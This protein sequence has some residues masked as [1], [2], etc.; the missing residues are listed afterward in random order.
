MTTTEPKTQPLELDQIRLDGGTQVRVEINND[1]V[2]E[3]AEARKDGAVLPP[4]VVFFDGSDYWLAD[5]FH[6]FHSAKRNKAKSIR[7]EVRTGDRRE[8]ILCAVGSNTAHGLRRSNADKRNAI[9]TLLKDADWGKKSDR[10]I[11][12]TAH[13]SD[14]TVASVRDQLRKSAVGNATSA[15]ENGD[16][17]KRTGRD[18]KERAASSGGATANGDPSAGDAGKKS[19]MELFENLDKAIGKAIRDVDEVGMGAEHDE[20]L[21][22]LSQVL[23]KANRWRRKLA[24]TDDFAG[25]TAPVDGLKRPV[26]QEALWPAFR[27][28]QEISGKM[29]LV[30]SIRTFVGDLIGTDIGSRLEAEDLRHWDTSL[31]ALGKFLKFARPYAVC[32]YCNASDK[33]CPAC[34]GEGWINKISYDQ[35]PAEKKPK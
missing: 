8:A 16:S 15:T 12:E 1:A 22:D 24:N 14:K 34:K 6:R 29:R 27:V 33:K 21:N 7:A 18:G 19:A 23:E 11:A 10:W 9:S 13:V 31:E 2:A 25:T 32:V 26:S 3:Y 30:S 35:A 5:G 4:V 28:A 17:G 20:L